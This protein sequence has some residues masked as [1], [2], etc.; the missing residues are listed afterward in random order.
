MK[1]YVAVFLSVFLAELGDKTQLATLLDAG[2]SSTSEGP[3]GASLAGTEWADP[4]PAASGG[5]IGPGTQCPNGPKFD[6]PAK[7]KAS[8]SS[9]MGMA[10]A[11]TLDL[12]CEI[13]AKP[14]GVLGI[15]RV[16]ADTTT[17]TD[18][19]TIGASF[20]ADWSKGAT[21]IEYRD[22]KVGAKDGVEVR[23]RIDGHVNR[24]FVVRPAA[25]TIVVHWGGLDD[26]EHTAGLPAYILAR[27]SAA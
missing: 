10:V 15:M 9:D 4:A 17:N 25:A 1:A 7:W 20:V 18:L 8:D 2:A 19:R 6:I 24:A 26:D 14:A 22:H 21:E 13:D 23:Y 5:R 16:F 27:N 3:K 11:N 12:L